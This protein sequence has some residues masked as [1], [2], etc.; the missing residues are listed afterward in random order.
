LER[1]YATS[2]RISVAM[3]QNS[4]ISAYLIT[5]LRIS[6]VDRQTSG[7]TLAPVCPKSV[8]G[9]KTGSHR[10]LFDHLVGSGEQRR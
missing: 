3:R 7:K 5:A 10:A 4:N 1:S 6:A 9:A 8:L 2:G